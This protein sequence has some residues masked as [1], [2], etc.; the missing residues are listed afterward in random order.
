[1]RWHACCF[2]FCSIMPTNSNGCNELKLFSFFF[3]KAMS[4]RRG[5]EWL[6]LRNVESLQGPEFGSRMSMSCR[7]ISR[8]Q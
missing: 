3:R 7:G 4:T 5:T 6:E 2:V 8:R 1:M